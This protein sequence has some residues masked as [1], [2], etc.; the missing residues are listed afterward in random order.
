MNF[1]RYFASVAVANGYIYVAGGEI[2]GGI[3]QSEVD[4]YNPKRDEWIKVASMNKPRTTFA[5]I[6]SNEFLY[7]LG[8]GE[9]VIERYDPWSTSWAEVCERSCSKTSFLIFPSK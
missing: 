7:A 8:G 3:V 4:C 6:K 2:C 5:L 9:A 1:A